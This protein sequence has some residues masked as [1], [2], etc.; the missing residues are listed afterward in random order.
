LLHFH[1]RIIALTVVVTLENISI[2]TPRLAN[3][4]T[5][6]LQTLVLALVVDRL[7]D[8][9]RGMEKVVNTLDF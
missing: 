1:V 3:T 7:A 8:F 6:A 9:N 5:T 4:S 2:L